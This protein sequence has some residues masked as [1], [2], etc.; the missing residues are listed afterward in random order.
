MRVS[1]FF[2][3]Q[4]PCIG[5]Q[6]IPSDNTAD[7]AGRHTN[8]GIISNSFV[9]SRYRPSH[10]IKRFALLAKPH[11][12]RH[13][14]AILAEGLERYVFLAVNRWRNLIGHGFILRLQVGRKEVSLMAVVRLLLVEIAPA[15]ASVLQAL[16]AQMDA[17]ALGTP[18]KEIS[19]GRGSCAS[20][21]TA[22]LLRART[23]SHGRHRP[24]IR[25]RRSPGSLCGT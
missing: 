17:R 11:R 25:R 24:G 21:F 23:I 1:V 14:H 4:K 9:L 18:Q 3:G 7:G 15:A 6:F 20:S 10:H 22:S 19:R 12:R 5:G 13:R 2:H 8:L 16:H